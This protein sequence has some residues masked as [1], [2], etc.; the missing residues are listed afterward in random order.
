MVTPILFSPLL[1]EDQAA[2]ARGVTDL[3]LK[4][5]L[6]SIGA[7]KAPG[8]DG[9]QAL[10]FRKFWH[11]VGSSICSLVKKIIHTSKRETTT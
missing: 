7:F 8:P 6:F 4:D 11:V 3:E 10:F 2:F 1:P 5:A 9:Y